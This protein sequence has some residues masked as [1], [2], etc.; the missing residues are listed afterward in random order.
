MSAEP[1]FSVRAGDIFPEEFPNFLALPGAAHSGLFDWHADLFHADFWRRIQSR[2]RA[3]EIPEVF[4]YRPE[5]RLGAA[6]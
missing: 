5:R 1:W 4:P 3:G 2:L 6:S